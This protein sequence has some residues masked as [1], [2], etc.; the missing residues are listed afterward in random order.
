M[1][2]MTLVRGDT[3]AR[4][5]RIGPGVATAVALAAGMLVCIPWILAVT[6]WVAGGHP[7]GDPGA[8]RQQ[9]LRKISSALPV[10]AIVDRNTDAGPQWTS[11]DG[12]PGTEGWSD[13]TVDY[14]FT[15]ALSSK[16]VLAHAATQM[17]ARHW[18]L[19]PHRPPMPGEY[20]EWAKT[21]AGKPAHAQLGTF[22]ATPSVSS[23]D[24]VATAPP[25]GQRSSGC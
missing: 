20:M 4:P 11:C 7:G 24:L 8:V 22:H 14:Q 2:P 21:I 12:R 23:W 9:E 19:L 6:G 10:G 13:L 25:D 18:T 3:Q 17:A 16:E 5:G 1:S 15:S